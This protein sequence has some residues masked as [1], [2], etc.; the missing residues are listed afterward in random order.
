M[1]TLTETII[2]LADSH[3]TLYYLGA[4]SA[5]QPAPLML[6]NAQDYRSLYKTV[7]A[8]APVNYNSV[9][10]DTSAT[11]LSKFSP[12]YRKNKY[13]ARYLWGAPPATYHEWAW[14]YFIPIEIS[15]IPRVE[16]ILDSRFEFKVSPVPRILLYPFGWV[17][18]LSLLLTGP[19]TLADLSAFMSH[20]FTE[21]AF[22]IIPNL[23]SSSESSERYSLKDVFDYIA[24]GTRID[25]FGA[26]KTRDFNSQDTIAV[27]TVLRKYGGALSLKALSHATEND[28]LKI[29]NP[30]G[31]ATSGQF[32]DY[33][34]Q[35]DTREICE[36]IV[37]NDCKR[38]MW[39]ESLLQPMIRRYEHLRCY[40]NNTFHSLVQ[41]RKLSDL[42]IISDKQ[43]TL[44]GSL[45]ELVENAV[46]I[47]ENPNYMNA[48]LKD[49]LRT[50]KVINSIN[51]IKKR[52]QKEETK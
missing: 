18:W 3:T 25:A 17:A 36:Y 6:G 49:F 42:L 20:I 23:G 30:S 32:S 10:R 33:I 46:N 51:S 44:S 40:H 41:A 13:W 52:Y 8:F 14:E 31:P 7:A 2:D 22:H 43:K 12:A 38:F 15:L 48:S 21:K 29:V 27:V 26:N 34:F 5:E 11:I 24:Q 37:M 35:R 4:N 39:I 1:T 9:A 50:P 28:L 16:F 19:H 45:S 47:L